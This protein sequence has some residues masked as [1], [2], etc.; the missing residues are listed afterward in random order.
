MVAVAALTGDLATEDLATENDAQRLARSQA[1][2]KQITTGTICHF[3]AAMVESAFDGCEP[4]H[5]D[6]FLSIFL[7]DSSF[8]FFFSLRT[9]ARTSAIWFARLPMTEK[10]TFGS[11]L[12]S[13]TEG[14]DKPLKYP[15]TFNRADISVVTKMD[16]AEAVEF[17]W[18]AACN[19]NSGL[20]SWDA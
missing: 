7:I 9:S 4:E 6:F 3:E 20:A 11:Y 19:D 15:S 18:D 12:I 10:K 14:E 8:R 17:D 1:P 16:L 2:V 5:L 13:V